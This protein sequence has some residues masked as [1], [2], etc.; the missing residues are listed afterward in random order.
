VSKTDPSTSANDRYYAYDESG[1]LLGE[2][3]AN[4]ARVQE[5]VWLDDTLV[6]VLSSHDGSTYQYVETDHL[7]TPR[8]VIKPSTNEIVWRWNLTPTAFGEHAPVQDPDADSTDYVLNLRY[9]GQW[10][11]AESGNHYNYFRDYDPNTGRYIESD[12]I[13]LLGGGLTYAYVRSRPLRKYDPLGLVD[14]NLYGTSDP[15]HNG[16]EKYNSKNGSFTVGGHGNPTIMVDQFGNP[17]TA[18]QLAK[19][20]LASKKYMP[21]QTVEI[22]ACNVG[23]DPE[24]GTKSFAEQVAVALNNGSRVGGADD[25]VWFEHEGRNVLIAPIKGSTITWRNFTRGDGAP[26]PEMSHT[27]GLVFY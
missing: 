3:L 1:H 8:A 27:G 9:P 15:S 25:F 17:L 2:Y 20:I 26:G 19:M 6:A 14:L 4:G 5:Y 22:Y 10:Y 16:A 21:G 11:D 7:G 24:D 12:P 18:T 23:R 13:G